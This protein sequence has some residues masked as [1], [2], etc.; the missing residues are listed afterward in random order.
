[1]R[2]GVVLVRDG[3]ERVEG[4]Q[5][6]VERV[7]VGISGGVLSALA[8]WGGKRVKGQGSRRG[9]RSSSKIISSGVTSTPIAGTTSG[10]GVRG[11]AFAAALTESLQA[12]AGCDVLRQL[13]LLDDA[14]VRGD[15]CLPER[16]LEPVL[17]RELR[18]IRQLCGLVVGPHGARAARARI[19]PVPLCVRARETSLSGLRCAGSR[20]VARA[21]PL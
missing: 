6:K 16:V 15:S 12:R 4:I 7:G 2:P 18:R 8:C 5:A 9:C 3:E 21:C 19:S 17:P 11:G 10:C 20:G 13:G 1:V 14:L